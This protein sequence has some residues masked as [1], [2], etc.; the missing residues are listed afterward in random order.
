MT[1]IQV[2][3]ILGGGF[4][5]ILCSPRFGE[6]I[7]FDDHIFQRDQMTGAIDRGDRPDSQIHRRF[8]E[9]SQDA[10]KEYTVASKYCI[11]IGSVAN[12]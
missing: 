1:L 6:M 11:A 2:S 4:K 7:H 8:A 3:E 10:K 12:I 5:Y 9:D